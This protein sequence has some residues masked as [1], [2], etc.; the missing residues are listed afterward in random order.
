MEPRLEHL[1]QPGPHSRRGAPP[2]ARDHHGRPSPRVLALALRPR[3]D[4]RATRRVAA[5]RRE[6]PPLRDRGISLLT[7]FT[8]AALLIVALVCVVGSVDRWWILI[9]VM[10][11]DFAVTGAVLA[12]M[13]R[14]LDDDSGRELDQSGRGGTLAHKRGQSAPRVYAAGGPARRRSRALGRSQ[15]AVNARRAAARSRRPTSEPRVVSPRRRHASRGNSLPACRRQRLQAGCRYRSRSFEPAGASSAS[16]VHLRGGTRPMTTRAIRASWA[17]GESLQAV[18]RQ[19]GRSPGS[20]VAPC[21][22]TRTASPSAAPAMDRRRGR[23]AARRL[24]RRPHVRRD[25]PNLARTLAGGG[26][27]TRP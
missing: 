9:P 4:D 25:R 5:L 3:Q 23:G 15:D 21:P 16:T 26:R 14:L 24:R 1:R 13:V 17:A 20:L 22:N 10:A 12:M 19:L 18:A 2:R 7:I 6:S 27:R 8:T 11:V